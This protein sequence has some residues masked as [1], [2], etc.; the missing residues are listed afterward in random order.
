M[1][2]HGGCDLMWLIQVRS[3]HLNTLKRPC[4]LHADFSSDL[5]CCLSLVLAQLSSEC[6]V[7]VCAEFKKSAQ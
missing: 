2:C 3:H 6:S 5:L 7:S 1:H 4:V